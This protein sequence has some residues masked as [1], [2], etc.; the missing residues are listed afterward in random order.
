MR[1]SLGSKLIL[2]WCLLAAPGLVTAGPL[3]QALDSC[4]AR[5]EAMHSENTDHPRYRW[6]HLCRELVPYQQLL[7]NYPIQ[8]KLG[9]QITL[10]QLYDLRIII[11][12]ARKP[13]SG[14]QAQL[15]SLTEL[16][17]NIREVDPQQFTPPK[18]LFEQLY[19]EVV[20]W[21]REKF[22]LDEEGGESQLKD[23]ISS[24][25][26]FVVWLEENKQTILN[27]LIL[28]FI[29]ITLA[30]IYSVV[31]PTGIRGLFGRRVQPH[32]T[33]TPVEVDESIAETNAGLAAAIARLYHS[34]LQL[35]E[36]HQKLQRHPALTIWDYQRR[37]DAD[38]RE[39]YTSLGQQVEYSNYSQHQIEDAQYQE[40]K[41]A[42]QSL[43]ARLGEDNA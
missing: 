12:D 17:S 1:I 29:L 2:A 26:S 39:P 31:S 22:A 30:A 13:V 25:E 3:Q 40:A 37:L 38:L 18:G 14:K 43:S 24:M 7:R 28:I 23:F 19:D 15:K 4:I 34:A 27:T 5:L 11:N 6:R 41:A 32:T 21:I 9:S 42:Y 8:P 10:Q 20:D 35:L 33:A 16:V 36:Q